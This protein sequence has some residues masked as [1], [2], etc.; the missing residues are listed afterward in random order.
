MERTAVWPARAAQP[1][2]A[3]VEPAALNVDH[4]AVHHSYF[5]F[6]LKLNREQRGCT[7][8]ITLELLEKYTEQNVDEMAFA[9][10]AHH[11]AKRPVALHTP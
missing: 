7:R 3:D 10:V 6:L 9:K 2:C 8:W 5:L 4:T 1:R 11:L